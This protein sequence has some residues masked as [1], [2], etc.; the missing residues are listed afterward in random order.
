MEQ[1]LQHNWL[2]EEH[3]NLRGGGGSNVDD[4]SDEPFEIAEYPPQPGVL[5][6]SEIEQSRAQRMN[7]A[8]TVLALRD[9]TRHFNVLPVSAN[10]ECFL[11]SL[12]VETGTDL[13]INNVR[14]IYVMLIESLMLAKEE[15]IDF[16]SENSETM[17]ARRSY[18]QRIRC[19]NDCLENLSN[20]DIYCLDKL[21]GLAINEDAL[22]D[23]H[24]CDTI[25]IFAFLK[26]VAASAYIV[27][28]TQN[29]R[30][31]YFHEGIL[32]EQPASD[33]VTIVNFSLI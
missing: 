5:E 20:F 28:A 26:R 19:Y 31:L 10:G 22:L 12:A 29:A 11:R 33:T 18:I 17:N 15:S 30:D 24:W 27:K 6:F 14:I 16:Y 23:R 4:M 8:N 1:I 25:E 2:A 3:P 9:D 13:Y 32:C 21:E 7:H